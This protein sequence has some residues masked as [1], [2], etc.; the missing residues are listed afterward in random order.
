M[1]VST[2]ARSTFNVRIVS[3]DM[4]EG[5]RIDGVLCSTAFILDEEFSFFAFFY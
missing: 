4:T 1:G 3:V 5:I 2:S